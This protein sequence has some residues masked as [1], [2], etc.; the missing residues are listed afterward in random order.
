[1]EE[2][3][4]R[5]GIAVLKISISEYREQVLLHVT[6]ELVLIGDSCCPVRN[7]RLAQVCVMCRV[8]NAVSRSE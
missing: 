4:S 7:M 6:V 8:G 1:M 2:D 3:V 5:Q